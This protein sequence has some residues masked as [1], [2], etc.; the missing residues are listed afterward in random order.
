MSEVTIR[1]ARDTRTGRDLSLPDGRLLCTLGLRREAG[2]QPGSREMTLTRHVFLTGSGCFFAFFGVFWSLPAGADSGC[3]SCLAPETL[4]SLAEQGYPASEYEVLGSWQETALLDP[5][6]SLWGYHLKHLAS[7]EWVD[8]YA[9]ESGR[10]LDAFELAL[11][12]IR[13]KNWKTVPVEQ[14]AEYPASMASLAGTEVRPEPV[15][16]KVVTKAAVPVVALGELDVDALL[17]EDEGRVPYEAAKGP[18]RIGVVREMAPIKVSR[19]AVSA[20]VWTQLGDGTEVW[21]VTLESPGAVAIRLHFVDMTLPAGTRITLFD[22]HDPS[23]SYAVEPQGENEA[24]SV[25][26]LSDTVTVECVIEPGAALEGPSFT[27]QDL[28]HTYRRVGEK[29]DDDD[30][31]G[32]CNLDVACYPDWY[33]SSLAVAGYNFVQTGSTTMNQLYCTG[34]FV[35]DMNTATTVPLF[36]TAYHCFNLSGGPISPSKMTSMEFYWWYQT[37]SCGGATPDLDDVQRSAIATDLLSAQPLQ[38]YVGNVLFDGTDH[39][40]LRLHQNPPSPVVYAGW[41]GSQVPVGAAVTTIHHPRGSH[42]RISFGNK[43]SEEPIHHPAGKFHQVFWSEGTTEGGSSGSGL[44]LTE[45]QL[46]IGQLYGGWASCDAL[47]SPDYYGRFDITCSMIRQW[48]MPQDAFDLDN[49]GA[50]DAADLQLV[51][52]ACLL[53]PVQTLPDVNYSGTVDAVDIQHLVLA[54]KAGK[55]LGN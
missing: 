7:G 3:V 49:S 2:G 23:Q 27:I 24:W 30:L 17:A 48:L 16:P 46:L 33:D 38:Y 39:V 20:G 9:D 35:A 45:S 42:K 5:D 51:V 4:T 32:L 6:V 34:T 29:A 21:A 37:P 41:T 22:A 11:L 53:V 8:V 10:V 50:V 47:D 18:Q 43:G 36:L 52:N 31:A 25:S 1:I 15:S 26:C 55:V 13:P 28:V 12:G 19:Q 44:F 54:V 14:A 40:F